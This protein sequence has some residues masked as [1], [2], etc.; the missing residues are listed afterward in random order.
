MRNCLLWFEIGVQA[1]HTI[2]AFYRRWL[3]R[4]KYWARYAVAVAAALRI[5]V[6]SNCFYCLCWID[7][8]LSLL[9]TLS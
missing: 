3:W 6:I 8:S 1:A 5:Q 4:T 9:V 2:Q 7:H